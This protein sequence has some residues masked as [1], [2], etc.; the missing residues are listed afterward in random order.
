[1]HLSLIDLCPSC[2][3]VTGMPGAGK[4]TV[5]D[6]LARRLPKA[7][8]LSGDVVAGMIRGGRVWALGEPADEARRQV[9]LT[10][11]NLAMLAN[12]FT[13]AGF[14]AVI[15]TVIPDRAHLEALIAALAAAPMLVV[16]SPGV[17]ACQARN[18]TR[19]ED[20]RWEFAGYEQLEVDMASGFG[21]LG[22]W[23]D[24]AKLTPGQTVEQMVIEAPE[25]ALLLPAC[26]AAAKTVGPADAH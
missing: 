21:E 8:R 10:T 18:A 1:M 6:L 25:R 15:E 12:N 3:I 7:A 24:T 13:A 9:E 23:L 2:L 11:R 22:W 26:L 14:T 16:L 5:A 19:G 17:A 4:S 20:E